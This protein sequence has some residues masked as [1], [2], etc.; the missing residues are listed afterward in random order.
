MTKKIFAPISDRASLTTML[1]LFSIPS[2]AFS[3]KK[4]QRENFTMCGRL[5]D[6]FEVSVWC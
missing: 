1:D 3:N 5:D 4:E 2:L 6:F